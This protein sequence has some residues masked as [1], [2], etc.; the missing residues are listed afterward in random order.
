MKITALDS[1]SKK[2]LQ[3]QDINLQIR[4]QNS[5]SLTVKT[6]KEGKFWLDDSYLGHQIASTM[7]CPSSGGSVGQFIP[8]TDGGRLVVV[9]TKEKATAPAGSH[10]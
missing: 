3:N 7:G 4:G 10:K 1:N 2:P 6:D 5:G 9:C 8:A